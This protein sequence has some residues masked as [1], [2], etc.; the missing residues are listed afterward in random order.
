[1]SANIWEV[2][3]LDKLIKLLKENTK[4]F[5]I[6]SLL[7]ESSPHQD[8]K[9]IIKFMKDKC[10]EYPNLTFVLYT[11][12]LNEMNKFDLFKK[13]QVEE[14]PYVFHIYDTVNIYITIEK[15][16]DVAL[17]EIFEDNNVKKNY[18]DNLK[19]FLNSTKS[20]PESTRDSDGKNTPQRLGLVSPLQSP[21]SSTQ[22]LRPIQQAQQ[23]QQEQKIQTHL[24]AQQNQLNFNQQ[25]QIP[26]E[27]P[28]VI[29]QKKLLQKLIIYKKKIDEYNTDFLQEIKNRKEEERDIRLENEK[30]KLKK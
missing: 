3:Q 27:D 2:T 28:K 23:I 18:E 14:Y 30:S 25:V 5:V 12:K 10:K 20:T 15:A 16:D 29:E 6:L 7:L 4:K 21:T 1:M 17:Y 24:N 8:R 9:M 13:T 11:V 22:N 19:E 26:Q